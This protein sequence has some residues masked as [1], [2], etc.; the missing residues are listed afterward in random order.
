[1]TTAIIFQNSNTFRLCMHI[2]HK[3]FCRMLEPPARSAKNRFYMSAFADF[4]STSEK[5]F[6]RAHRRTRSINRVCEIILY[7]IHLIFIETIR[8]HIFRKH[9]R[10]LVIKSDGDISDGTFDHSPSSIRFTPCIMLSL[11]SALKILIFSV[12]IFSDIF[13]P[14]GIILLTSDSR[15]ISVRSPVA[16]CTK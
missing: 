11:E 10:K 16:N 3:N 13:V 1:M 4:E 8:V 15:M 7:R 12:L 6:S 14:T 2:S 9:P 5:V